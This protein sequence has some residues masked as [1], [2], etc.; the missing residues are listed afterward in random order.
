MAGGG[1]GVPPP[2]AALLRQLRPPATPEDWCAAARASAAQAAAA[3]TALRGGADPAAVWGELRAQL[4]PLCIEAGA[5]AP[6]AGQPPSWELVT[7]QQQQQPRRRRAPTRSVR[8]SVQLSCAVPAQGEVVVRDA[9]AG[10]LWACRLSRSGQ[11]I[12]VLRLGQGG[13]TPERAARHIVWDGAGAVVFPELACGINVSEGERAEALGGLRALAEAAGAKHNIPT[14]VED[15]TEEPPECYVPPLPQFQ[16]ALAVGDPLRLREGAS[17][18]EYLAD[19]AFLHSACCAPTADALGALLRRRYDPCQIAAER[20]RGEPPPPGRRDGWRGLVDSDGCAAVAAALAPVFEPEALVEVATADGTWHR[21]R[22]LRAA[23]AETAS[24][25]ASYDVVF[26]D[27]EE[28]PA[29]STSELRPIEA[30]APLPLPDG[31]E[32]ATRR[33]GLD[34]EPTLLL[35]GAAPHAARC[36]G[37]RLTHVDGERVCTLEEADEAVEGAAATD[38]ARGA[39]AAGAAVL[40]FDDTAPPPPPPPAA[41]AELLLIRSAERPEANGL[42]RWLGVG[43]AD[44]R[45]GMP[46][47]AQ[48][49]G[50]GGDGRQL[51]ELASRGGFWVLGP[52]GGVAE[53]YAEVASAAPHGGKQYPQQVGAWRCS[54]QEEWVAEWLDAP[55]TSVCE[56]A[57][58]VRKA[59]GTTL[60]MVFQDP[61]ELRLEGCEQGSAAD[62]YGLQRFRGRRL[63]RVA[64]A[65]TAAALRSASPAD[66]DD[67]GELRRALGRCT[68]AALHFDAPG[69]GSP[70]GAGSPSMRQWVRRRRSEGAAAAAAAPAC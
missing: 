49:Q 38:S 39:A 33:L 48:L 23:A 2:L 15:V 9:A 13:A 28:W 64:A 37:L 22:V 53:G 68:Y 50:S 36:V 57:T 3:Y 62:W 19:A 4:A 54:S 51:W 60:G 59:A 67:L 7:V 35:A 41:A 34:L 12:A 31:E 17:P 40:R 56:A 21:A 20:V 52:Q 14:R 27:T 11:G 46:V 65:P 45:E 25:A 6:A 69:E 30:A 44:L 55:G 63:C 16:R 61:G 47:W 10:H 24:G 5:R 58:S 70:T 32:S 66:V 43:D 42:Y 8:T 1:G 18:S 26:D 29:V